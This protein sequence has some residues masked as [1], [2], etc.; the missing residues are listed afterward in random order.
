SGVASLETARDRET[1]ET[2]RITDR[3]GEVLWEIFGEGK[4]T[5]IPLS[6]IPDYFIK[7]TIA[8]EDDTFYENIG[9]DAP[10]LAAAVIANVRNPDARPVGGSTITQQIVRHIAFDYE[11]RT[12]VSYDRKIKELVLAWMMNRDFTKDE[13]L[14]M[15]LNEI[16]YGNLAY[17]VEAAARTYFAKPASALT[18]GESSLLAGL[19]QSPVDLDP[20]TNLEGAKE[21]QWL[22]LNLMVSEGFIDQAT[23]ETAYL[24]PLNFAAQEV[25]LEAPHFAVYVRQL[26]EQQYGAELVANGGLRV[27]TSLDMEFQ[28]LAEGLARQH[29]GQVDPAKNL[30]NAALVAMKP[31]TGEILAML[32]SVDYENEAI[33][34]HVNVTLSP[35]Q[36]GSSIKPLTYAAAL[37]PT[38]PA[39]PEGGAPRWTAA[40]ILWDVP[41]KYEQAV[42]EPY[43][44]VNYDGAFHGP[45]RL[46]AA[47][48]NSYNIP[49]VLLLQDIGVP[50]LLEFGR[51][52]GLDSWTGDSSQYGLSLT[53]GGGEVT[54]LELTTAYAALANGGN[55]VAPVAILRV[56]RT[57]G[58]VLY[59]YQ[60]SEPQ[61]VI[62]ERVAYVISNILDDDQARIP[63]MGS[64]NPMEL[65]FPAAAKTGTTNDFRDNWTM[66]YTPGLVVGVW[67]GNTDNSPMVHI[68]GLEGAAP[69]WS[70]YMQGVYSNGG[71]VARLE[72]N[73][74]VPPSEFIRPL[75]LTERPLCALTS[76][77]VGSIDCVPAGEELF[78]ESGLPPT[79]M[80]TVEGPAV[81]WEKLDPAVWRAVAMPLPPPTPEEIALIPPEQLE[82]QPPPQLFCHF[83]EGTALELLPPTAAPQVFLSPPHNAESLKPA[84]E[85][86]QANNIAILPTATCTE[87]MLAES[88]GQGQTAVWRITSPADGDI[89]KGNV[90]IIGTASFDPAE[91]EFYKI[92]L[93]IPNGGDIQ[94]LTLGE[95]HNTPVVNGQLEYLQ[96]EG[97]PPGVYYLRLIV[98]Q[99]SN[100]V[101][102]PHQIQIIVEAP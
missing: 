92:E 3:N 18:L 66:G 26:L 101:G 16:Y 61:R 65:P 60:P 48:A 63:A 71:L 69:L 53:L 46:R 87:E 13:I 86:A 54:P 40:D 98:I 52:L 62:D 79:P 12:A 50:R 30:T 70:S 8:V 64:P 80:P 21:R 7:A 93:G 72:V 34:G 29:V 24:E 96:A 78:L 82:D 56:E 19:P 39:S 35:Q 58:E 14:E 89:V 68:S 81:F 22:I 5:R 73:G 99:D 85:W 44:P 83:A 76:A 41:V 10:S 90:P 51:A 47:L 31:G 32:G 1:F 94:W 45:V 49:A 36:P 37:S 97:L 23:A 11:E 77:A 42:G 88:L 6:E 38:D 15:Y 43:A 100:Y 57:N 74:Q 67:T 27:T 59:E 84:H 2:T 25:S 17:G 4:R 95:T 28:R 102:E 55:R 75:G 20:F 91:V 33:D 9:L